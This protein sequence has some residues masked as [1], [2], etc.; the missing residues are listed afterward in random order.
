MKTIFTSTLLGFLH[1]CIKKIYVSNFRVHI[2]RYFV[3]SK[4]KTIRNRLAN[5]LNATV[6][7]NE[8]KLHWRKTLFKLILLTNGYQ[9]VD[10]DPSVLVRNSCNHKSFIPMGKERVYA[11]SIRVHLHNTETL[12]IV[13]RTY[14]N[15]CLANSYLYV[16]ISV[17]R[18]MT[19]KYRASGLTNDYMPSYYLKYDF[20]SINYDRV[21]SFTSLLWN[22]RRF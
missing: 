19:I 21:Q 16:V 12:Q 15:N 9:R 22:N 18:F 14:S 20:K 2:T 10:R 17:E 5:L 8:N 1:Q 7:Q 6:V 13:Q 3:D 11:L 4:V